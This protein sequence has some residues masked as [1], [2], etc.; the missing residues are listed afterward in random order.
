MRT[1]SNCKHRRFESYFG[2]D[3]CSIYEMSATEE[4]DINNAKDCDRYEEETEEDRHCPS[5]TEGD[6]GPGNPWDAPGM[7]IKDYI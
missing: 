1:C 3:Y 2:Y 4:E 5:S 6:Y 7:S